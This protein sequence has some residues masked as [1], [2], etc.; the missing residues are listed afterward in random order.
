MKIKMVLMNILLTAINRDNY[1]KETFI[2][3]LDLHG[4]LEV[5]WSAVFSSPFVSARKELRQNN[6]S[7]VS[8]QNLF[9]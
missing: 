8:F 2:L 4:F 3:V 1:K 5:L 6:E 9:Y 7:K